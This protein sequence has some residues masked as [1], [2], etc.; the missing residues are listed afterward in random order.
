[1]GA[2]LHRKAPS[3]YSNRELFPPTFLPLHKQ[4]ASGLKRKDLTL[5]GENDASRSKWE[6]QKQFLKDGLDSIPWADWGRVHKERKG[7]QWG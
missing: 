3:V 6:N 4:N 7:E 1:M 5:K 2:V